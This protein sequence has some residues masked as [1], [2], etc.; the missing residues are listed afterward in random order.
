MSCCMARSSGSDGSSERTTSGQESWCSTRCGPTSARCAHHSALAGAGSV[1]PASAAMAFRFGAVIASRPGVHV[2]CICQARSSCGASHRA[3]PGTWYGSDCC[4]RPSR[5]S[6]PHHE[7]DQALHGLL[8]AECGVVHTSLA[9]FAFDVGAEKVGTRTYR[10]SLRPFG[11][12]EGISDIHLR[13]FRE[14]GRA[15]MAILQ[16]QLDNNS[17]FA[18]PATQFLF[19]RASPL[20][21]HQAGCRPTT[22]S[23][24]S[25][26]RGIGQESALI[27]Q[28]FVPKAALRS[29]E[30]AHAAH[31]GGCDG[32][33]RR[34]VALGLLGRRAEREPAHVR[35]SQRSAGRIR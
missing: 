26:A 19:H 1:S 33:G 29:V 14:D 2:S 24:E 5:N 25:F 35:R 18:N 23:P 15:L 20:V 16:R 32:A 4:R 22:R 34:F 9:E 30:C 8:L 27:A 21:A 13:W 7:Q 11:L 31:T 17:E 28:S 3:K 12:P 10:A 6:L